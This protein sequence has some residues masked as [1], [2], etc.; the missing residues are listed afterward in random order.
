M[1]QF[2]SDQCVVGTPCVKVMLSDLSITDTRV[3]IW[4]QASELTV[5]RARLDRVGQGIDFHPLMAASF[6]QLSV[7]LLGT[8]QC[9]NLS[10]PS[11][12]Q[13]S[14]FDL[15]PGPGTGIMV[16]QPGSTF[17]L[18]DGLMHDGASGVVSSAPLTPSQFQRVMMRKIDTPITIGQ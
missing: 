16:K 5:K 15:S 3:G 12:F 9:V 8:S 10:R 1:A 18:K 13:L 6:D 17:V 7:N 4:A 2:G 11:S 14:H